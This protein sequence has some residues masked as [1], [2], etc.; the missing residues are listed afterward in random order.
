MDK[1]TIVL[2]ENGKSYKMTKIVFYGGDSGFGIF[3]PYHKSKTG[4]LSKMKFD[5]RLKEA[6]ITNEES[7][8]FSADDKVKLSYHSDGFVQFSGVNDNII[9]GRDPVTHQP[10]GMGLFTYPLSDPH[11]GAPAVGGTFWGLNDYTEFLA[12]KRDEKVLV[13]NESDYYYRHCNNIN[14]NGYILEIFLLDCADKAMIADVNDRQIIR[15]QF[16]NYE[17]PNTQFNLR[18]V[19]HYDSNYILGL[20]V[21]RTKVHFPS[22]S[23]YALSSPGQK[24]GDHIGIVLEAMYPLDLDIFNPQQ[25]LNYTPKT[26]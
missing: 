18:I 4:L 23:G 10:R 21:S 20:L 3:A 15:Y 26:H 1:F 14:W 13:F 17:V 25:N 11:N 8:E 9:S 12:P 7:I 22:S 24:T 5:Y 19:P 6:V 2:N 16:P